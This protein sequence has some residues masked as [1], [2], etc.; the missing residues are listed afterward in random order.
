[1]TD[2]IADPVYAAA[3]VDGRRWRR[4]WGAGLVIAAL[5]GGLLHDDGGAS[6]D[7]PVADP[8]VADR[9]T[10]PPRTFTVAAVGDLLPED[11]VMTRAAEAAAAAGSAAR[12]DFAPLLAPITPIIRWADL[13]ICH[14]ETPIGRPGDRVGAYGRSSF[15]G[16]LLLGPYE[17]AQAMRAAGFDRCST[18]SNHAWDLGAAGIASTLDA[19]DAAGLGHD[20]TARSPEEA[21]H[22]DVLTL[23]GVRVAHLSI[24]T[25]TNTPLP[26]DA[27][28]LDFVGN[29][30]EIVAE[31]DAARA[32]GAEVVIV[33]V[34]IAKEMVSTPMSYDRQ[35]IADLT[36]RAHVDLVIEHGP[37]VV[38]PVET[39]NGTLV[40][41][42]VGNLLSG[43]GL[44]NRGKYA[45]ERTLD[46]LLATVRFTETAPGVFAASPIT[47]AICNEREGRTVYAPGIALR[48]PA[49]DPA[50]AAE[51]YECMART[52][53]VVP[54]AQ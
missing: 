5:A 17:F 54:D 13:A 36:S 47:L 46:G 3:P 4:T 37:H 35:F 22:I 44:P 29:V 10:P 38:Q 21:A 14:M 43:M 45:D 32:A 30:D 48:D 23:G 39:V 11:R 24:T 9:L 31:V 12:Y 33:S 7:D 34:H 16:N 42:S 26:G 50:L 8:T 52:R 40:Y 49:L 20:G 53:A 15:G 27:W 2:A 41:W 1:M 6:A 51:L 25:F 18:A 19:M 28:R